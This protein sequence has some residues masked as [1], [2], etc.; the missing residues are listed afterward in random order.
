MKVLIINKHISYALG[1]S[2]MQCDLIAKGLFERGHEVVY[3]AVSLPED[4]KVES[5]Y[6]YYI[7][8]LD[9]SRESTV[10]SF[11][12]QH[13]PDI[14]YWRFNKHGL[15]KIIPPAKSLKIPFVYAVSHINDVTRFAYKP[16]KSSSLIGKIKAGLNILRQKLN[17]AIQFSYLK[18][19]SG[20]TSLNSDFIGKLDVPFQKV[21]K[22]SVPD[23][24]IPFQMK[25]PFV[26]WVS[27][28]KASKRP[29]SY[30]EL[31]RSCSDLDVTFL[32]VG[33]IQQ[34]RYEEIISKAQALPNFSYLGKKS[35]EEV[36]GVIKNALILVHTCEPEGFGN[37][38]IQAWM[39]SCPTVSLSFDPDNIIQKEGLGYVSGSQKQLEIDVRKLLEDNKLRIEMGEKAKKYA[40]QNFSANR[41]TEEVESFLK[42][43][44]DENR[45]HS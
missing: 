26:I 6:K 25:D 27:S 33:P 38:F 29:E 35:P 14:I 36:N 17:S 10:K 34:N 32:M 44:L 4:F 16:I 2:E 39:Q 40:I 19:I 18:E 28:I 24:A 12:E 15:D 7:C 21:I 8:K 43:L 3:G 30:I 37:N 5:V 11:L 9:L 31:A 13:Q 22:N 45:I 23:E 41:L 20:L 42:S 1:G